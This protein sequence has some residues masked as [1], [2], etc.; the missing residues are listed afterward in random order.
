MLC[1]FALVLVNTSWVT[2]G[3]YDG[4]DMELPD[5]SILLGPDLQEGE[6]LSFGQ[7]IRT[8]QNWL[9]ASMP[10]ETPEPIITVWKIS[11]FGEV[12]FMQRVFDPTGASGTQFGASIAVSQ[13]ADIFAVGAPG[14]DVVHVFAAVPPFDH[15]FTIN[16]PDSSFNGSRFGAAISIVDKR[17]AVGA[18]AYSTGSA[19]QE[20]AVLLYS[21]EGNAPTLL[22][23]SAPYVGVETGFGSSVD[24]RRDEDGNLR[25]ASGAPLAPP[26]DSGPTGQV[27]VFDC[28]YDTL[29]LVTVITPSVTTQ[30]AR[31]GES[32]AIIDSRK[33]VVSTIPLSKEDAS[34]VQIFDVAPGVWEL[35]QELENSGADWG[36]SFGAAL[37]VG[38]DGLIAVGSP[39]AGDQGYGSGAIVLFEFLSGGGRWIESDRILGYGTSAGAHFG[40]SV[41][42]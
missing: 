7:T 29:S 20:G 25:L 8:T 16:T 37:T 1:A 18:P 19:S 36:D 17:L 33:V 42:L 6:G 4:F 39:G 15:K 27:Q 2:A 11:D 21:I 24:L 26:L 38:D 14:D 34:T 35:D 31:F 12:E 41:S 28:T 3:E 13:T 10:G 5:G 32:V 22:D 40:T 23:G 9:F 30:P